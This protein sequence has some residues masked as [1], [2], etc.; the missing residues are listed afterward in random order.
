MAA[1]FPPMVEAPTPRFTA[2]VGT[3]LLMLGS[4]V[5]AGT[6]RQSLVGE[7]GAAG[8]YASASQ[9]YFTVEESSI[10]D[11]LDDGIETGS[12]GAIIN[13]GA[14]TIDATAPA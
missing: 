7:S 4:G 6:M 14:S 9:V 8:V 11:N 12:S 1:P 10:V 2:N 13:I 5:V 3:G